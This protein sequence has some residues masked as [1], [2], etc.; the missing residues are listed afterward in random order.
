MCPMSVMSPLLYS[1]RGLLEAWTAQC[2]LYMHR[3]RSNS[4]HPFSR[5]PS[6]RAVF[7]WLPPLRSMRHQLPHTRDDPRRASLLHTHT[8]ALSRAGL[9]CDIP[10]A[11]APRTSW[12]LIIAIARSV[13]L[14]SHVHALLSLIDL[15]NNY[16]Y[17][18][19][20]C[21]GLHTY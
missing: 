12:G 7:P 21:F 9:N 10:P 14:P 2:L 15:Q 20:W 5:A 17:V 13:W 1:H 3:A 19:R 11:K 18:A 6:T 4:G 8:E 16:M